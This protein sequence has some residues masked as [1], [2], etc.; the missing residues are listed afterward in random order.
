MIITDVFYK[1]EKMVST[2]SF[3]IKNVVHDN[4]YTVYI[5]K[6][7]GQH[8]LITM[9]FEMYKQIKNILV[10]NYTYKSDYFCC[11]IKISET[12]KIV[13]LAGI[14]IPEYEI[15]TI[16]TDCKIIL[17]F[18]KHVDVYTSITIY[19]LTKN[20]SKFISVAELENINSNKLT[21][22]SSE[23]SL[24]KIV[25]VLNLKFDNKNL[26]VSNEDNMLYDKNDNI[27]ESEIYHDTIKPL[28]YRQNI[29]KTGREQKQI[30]ATETVFKNHTNSIFDIESESNVGLKDN[31]NIKVVDVK[32]NISKLDFTVDTKK[33][34]DDML[35]NET[36]VDKNDH[37]ENIKHELNKKY[38]VRLKNSKLTNSELLKLHKQYFNDIIKLLKEYYSNLDSYT[39][40]SM[41]EY[42]SS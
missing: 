24:P 16:E 13:K 40:L 29:H 27:Q 33:S 7:I 17:Q 19:S 30:Y 34:T 36:S 37:L 14:I 20:V 12:G 32:K 8:V 11:K 41:I 26:S 2:N 1:T 31:K 15:K 23:K 21:I 28:Y 25:P 3:I 4:R 6:N 18:K 5:K 42:I 39:I 35:K 9:T 10:N 22:N 38:D